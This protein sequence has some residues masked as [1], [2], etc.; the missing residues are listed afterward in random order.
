MKSETDSKVLLAKRGERLKV[1][2]KKRKCREANFI[3]T[4]AYYSKGDTVSGSCSSY[5][6]P[7]APDGG[8]VQR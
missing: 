8:K 5:R 6:V 3:E 1:P 7:E 4:M 2:P